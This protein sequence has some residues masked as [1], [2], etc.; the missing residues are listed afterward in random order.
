MA[1]RVL[2]EYSL[3][4]WYFWLDGSNSVI[5]MEQKGCKPNSFGYRVRKNIS[6]PVQSQHVSGALKK[7]WPR[8]TVNLRATNICSQQQT[9]S[10][11]RILHVYPT[12][13]KNNHAGIVYA[14]TYCVIKT[15]CCAP[16][17]MRHSVK[18]HKLTCLDRMRTSHQTRW[19]LKY[20]FFNWT[21]TNWHIHG[22]WQ[23]HTW[24]STFFLTEA[25]FLRLL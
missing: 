6:K 2:L 3:L 22:T 10:I 8:G 23:L 7:F 25:S 19:Q 16:L 21:K 4:R 11:S 12:A 9:I 18:A 1:T 15:S 5:S 17:K 20:Q 24:L 13:K 14:T